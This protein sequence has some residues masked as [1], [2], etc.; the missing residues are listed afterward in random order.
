[1]PRDARGG[2]NCQD[3]FRR[4]NTASQPA[5]YG[6]LRTQAQKSRQG[7]LPADGIARL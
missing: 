7:R 6:A 3:P 2:F 4:N 1:M 5:R